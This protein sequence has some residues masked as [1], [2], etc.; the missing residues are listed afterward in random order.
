MYSNIP[1]MGVL[2]YHTLGQNKAA[3]EMNDFVRLC[4]PIKFSYLEFLHVQHD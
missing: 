4:L 2:L 1:V 3:T